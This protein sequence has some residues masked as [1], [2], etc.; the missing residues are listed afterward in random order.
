MS[1]HKQ[2]LLMLII[3]WWYCRVGLGRT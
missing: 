1:P 2:I 3:Y